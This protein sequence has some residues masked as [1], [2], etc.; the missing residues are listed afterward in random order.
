M[1]KN[2]IL[3]IFRINNRFTFLIL[4]MFFLRID[5]LVPDII[6]VV[7]K[8]AVASWT[9]YAAVI[10]GFILF[11]VFLVLYYWKH[12]E[13]NI[14]DFI[15]VFVACLVNGAI[16]YLLAILVFALIYGKTALNVFISCFESASATKYYLVSLA[17]MF[18]LYAI[19]W[20]GMLLLAN[21]VKNK[22]S[23]TKGGMQIY[24]NTIKI[25]FK[26]ILISL[27]AI[28]LQMVVM[29]GYA[30]LNMLVSQFKYSSL[31]GDLLSQGLCYVI[32][33]FVLTYLMSIFFNLAEYCV[34]EIEE[35][36]SGL[37][38]FTIVNVVLVALCIILNGFNFGYN[39]IDLISKD[40]DDHKQYSQLYSQYEDYHNALYESNIALSENEA[41]RAYVETLIT[42]KN[43]QTDYSASDNLLKQAITHCPNSSFV[44]LMKGRIYMA[45]ES[46]SDAINAL[47]S[48]LYLENANEVQYLTLL[49]AY[50]LNNEKEKSNDIIPLLLKKQYYYDSYT[51]LEKMSLK[52]L[53]EYQSKLEEQYNQLL[54]TYY[55]AKAFDQISC[56]EYTEGIKTLAEWVKFDNSLDANYYFSNI[57]T[58]YT[59]E[60]HDYQD[61]G[62]AVL[63]FA[64]LYEKQNPDQKND[65]MQYVANVLIATDNFS[66]CVNY[67][68][69]SYKTSN[70]E[71][72]YVYYGYSLYQSQKYQEAEAVVNELLSSNPNNY[73]GLYLLSL[74]EV[75]QSKY[76]D[77][78]A[79]INKVGEILLLQKDENVRNYLDKC[80]YE[81]SALLYHSINHNDLT[82]YIEEHGMSEISADYMMVYSNWALRLYDVSNEYS[83]KIIAIRDDLYTPYYIK[84]TNAY[85]NGQYDDAEKYFT[86][87]LECNRTDETLFH[88]GFVYAEKEEY[89]RAIRTWNEVRLALPVVNHKE[90]VNGYA[91]HSLNEIR[92]MKEHLGEVK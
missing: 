42:I 33:T 22:G 21:I 65:L 36:K 5:L 52:K 31:N 88:I 35:V 14:K 84:G 59:Y 69:D 17:S 29:F 15:G 62:K 45:R 34:D 57:A 8:N 7:S 55:F 49:K 90:D 68:K 72:L 43:N 25:F 67:L 60:G 77:S 83:D 78:I 74:I 40:S 92:M 2:N 56:G 71:R 58:N 11:I 19:L 26:N 20:F 48:S 79:T 37:P 85:E 61:A 87:A 30:K 51:D 12:E 23:L 1:E 10:V 39:T 24:L 54:Q 76:D 80:M 44:L 47:E 41:I 38:I 81:Y 16:L 4:S 3:S 32:L 89:G 6:M 86:K 46:Y 75:K 66:D 91:Y 70:N 9:N 64:D 73:E 13:H 18:A 53:Y 27:P 50:N 28:I 63:T 82:T